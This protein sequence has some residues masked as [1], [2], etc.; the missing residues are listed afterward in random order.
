MRA[1]AVAGGDGTRA[2]PFGLISGALAVATTG[3]TVAL[4]RGRWDEVVSLR[5]GMTLRGACAAETVLTSSAPSETAGVVNVA[6]RGT[7]LADLTIADA[8]R[9]GLW[10]S[11]GG[12]EL[13]VDGVI[14][15]H[16][17]VLG[18]LVSYGAHLTGTELVVRN[19]QS[20]AADLSFGGGLQ[21][22]ERATA[23]VTRVLIEGNRAF[24]LIAR[25]MGTSLR[26][27]DV[28]VRDTLSIEADGTFGN[29]LDVQAGASAE[30]ARALFE[31]NRDVAVFVEDAGASVRLED[32][33]V[34]DTQGEDV[35]HAF[36]R[37][38]V[39]QA[40]GSAVVARGLFEQNR[41]VSAFATGESA[42]IRLEDVVVRDTLSQESDSRFGNGLSLQGGARAELS[43]TLVT[44]NRHF[45]ILAD[46]VGTTLQL[47]D[48]VVRDTASQESDQAFGRGL[49]VQSGASALV[50]RAA[51]EQNRELGVFVAGAGTSV[52]LE[53]VVVRDTRSQE[54][55]GMSGRGLGVQGGASVDVARALLERNREVA[56]FAYDADTNVRLEDVVVR[57]TLPA[58]CGDG[59]PGRSGGMGVGS[60]GTA[61]LSLSRFLVARAA[62]CGVQ[63]ALD[64]ELDLADGEVRESSVGAC[65]Q[66]SGYA[67]SRLSTNVV[68][69]EN[70]TNIASTE[71]PVPDASS[72]L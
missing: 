68:Y 35:G 70:G 52:R 65:V 54:S 46:G 41:E 42:T 64:G 27:A 56:A 61:R 29:G 37:A 71:L 21:V 53:D 19:T 7:A 50:A 3:T 51:L 55:D 4:S 32:V 24:G 45:G 22:D 43:R 11:G 26:L 14:I 31:R 12:A 67:F 57:D 72:A 34:R 10:V 40:G 5:F 39:V 60:Y 63:V 18:G 47:D 1:G 23:D 15:D 9:P 48:V 69:V 30:L 6:V 38:L 28:A 33:V 25:G 58:E 36:G 59:C 13:R 8:P 66:V 62:V 20:R 49:G 2:A 44:R 17:G 16:A